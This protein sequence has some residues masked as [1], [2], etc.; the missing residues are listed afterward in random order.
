MRGP[1]RQK[2]NLADSSFYAWTKYYQI[3]ENTPNA[4]VS[5]YGKGALFAL[6][7]DLQIRA[8]TKNKQSLD[9]LMRLLWR[10]HGITFNGI[11]ENGLDDLVF[12]LLGQGFA[13]TWEEMKMYLALKRFLYKNG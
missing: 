8:F 3:D 12:D 9:D 2:K 10:K 7:L 4:V 6:G 5:H 11:P 1:G 13:E